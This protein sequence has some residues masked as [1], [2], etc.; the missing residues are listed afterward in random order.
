MYKYP[1]LQDRAWLTEQYVTNRLSTIKIGEMVG[2]KSDNSV[3]Q[4]LLRFGISPRGFREAQL[5][6]R[7]ELLI[8]EE[9]L[10]GCLLGDG[11]LA[12]FSKFS[13]VCAPY[14]AKRN[15]FRD[16]IEYV[17]SSFYKNFES[18]ISKEVHNHPIDKQTKL[19]YW[20]FRTFSDDSL[21]RYFDEWYP[22]PTRKK[23]IP[24][25]LLLTPKTLLHW[26][27]DD[28]SCSLR[29]PE[30][31]TKQLVITLSCQ[32]FN[33]EDQE[34]LCTE[35]DKLG[36]IAKP[37]YCNT[38]TGTLI[39]VAQRQAGDFLDLIGPCPVPSLAYKW[40]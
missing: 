4:A 13:K 36:I 16:H 40:K 25:G 39:K 11:R 8:D 7:P 34:R 21:V 24:A 2:C 12:K 26:F 3:R 15:K 28:G 32:C 9:V 18:R 1:E 22:E 5:K 37:T 19:T 33:L 10:N 23:V 29:R 14:F 6:E 27:M 35:I 31:K 30:S 20:A 38:G 17:A